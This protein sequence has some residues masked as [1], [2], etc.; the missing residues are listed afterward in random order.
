MRLLR[1][2]AGLYSRQ[3][4]LEAGIGFLG[5]QT[6]CVLWDACPF[7]KARALARLAARHCRV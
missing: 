7:F 2:N 6:A 3:M 4:L 1:A 5:D